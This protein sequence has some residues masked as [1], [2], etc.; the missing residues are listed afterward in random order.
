MEPVVSL[1]SP[2]WTLPDG[3]D[4]QEPGT[5]TGPLPET[6]RFGAYGVELPGEVGECGGE[7]GRQGQKSI[8]IIF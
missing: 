6:G 7:R 8:L 2:T 5:Y 3:R 1:R 4:F